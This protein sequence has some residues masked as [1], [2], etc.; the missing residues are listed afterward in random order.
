MFQPQ[1][2]VNQSQDNPLMMTPYMNTNADDADV[3]ILQQV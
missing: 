3:Q 2:P 1:A